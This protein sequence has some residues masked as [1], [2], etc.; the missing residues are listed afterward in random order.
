M[1]DISNFW[2][3]SKKR[4]FLNVNPNNNGIFPFEL[5]CQN[6]SLVEVASVEDLQVSDVCVHLLTWFLEPPTSPYWW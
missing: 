1:I 6:S 5:L 4:Y 3:F 2:W